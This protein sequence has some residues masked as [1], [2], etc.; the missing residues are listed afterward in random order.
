MVMFKAHQ[1]RNNTSHI[2]SGEEI[3]RPFRIRKDLFCIVI[4]KA[5]RAIPRTLREKQCLA[6]YLILCLP[7]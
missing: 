2:K 5:H 7:L 3:K 6:H 4:F 1:E